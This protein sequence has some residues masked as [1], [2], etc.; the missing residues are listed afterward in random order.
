M[1][2]RRGSAM[3]LVTLLAVLM[4]ITAVT[5]VG[6]TATKNRESYA[7]NKILV[8]RYAA[9]A[10]LQEAQ[11]KIEYED[12]ID[13]PDWFNTA[14]SQPDPVDTRWIPPQG[15]TADAA[16]VKLS[17]F[18]AAEALTRYGLTLGAD[19]YIVEA[20]ATCD[21][22]KA[23]LHMRVSY[24]VETTTSTS[25]SPNP[26][27]LFSKYLVWTT[28]PSDPS[29][30]WWNGISNGPVHIN[31]S[32]TISDKSTRMAMPFTVTETLAY[33]GPPYLT[34]WT[35]AEKD[36]LFDYDNDGALTSTPRPDLLNTSEIDAKTGSG[37]GKPAVTQPSYGDVQSRMLNAA[38]NQTA[39][40]PAL[41][42]LWVDPA[43]PRYQAGGPMYVGTIQYL[44]V[45]F[46]H[47]SSAGV[48]K[49]TA[50]I[51]VTGSSTTR[52]ANVVIP[53]GSP[54]ILYTPARIQSLTG[55]LYGQ[56]T[57]ASTYLGSPTTANWNPWN[58]G[59]FTVMSP[60]S[61]RI[62]DHV[63]LVDQ[64]GRP[65]Y[66]M[67][68]GSTAVAQP[69]RLGLTGV[70]INDSGGA[71][72]DSSASNWQSSGWV[73]KKNPNYNPASP[74]VLGLMCRGDLRVTST[75]QNWI[76]MFAHY[77][78]ENSGRIYAWYGNTRGNHAFLG[79]MISPQTNYF[80]YVVHYSDG[81]VA[82]QAGFT[83]GAYEMYDADFRTSPPPYWIAP[84]GVTTATVTT[85]TVT[86]FP[87][88]IYQINARD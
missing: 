7:L 81:S 14:R 25:S 38:V 47:D 57:V 2:R 84:A 15:T 46:A 3:L 80:G 83:K 88:A 40:S 22:S 21:R 53:P 51:T 71:N 41:A 73:F 87:G 9:E 49:T 42:D 58:L 18:D 8:C 26:A 79:S 52:T 82:H 24:R 68:D 66:W 32:V 23:T 29:V 60:P 54:T 19:E 77:S 50:Q 13:V 72:V 67:Y 1:N 69:S 39:S 43:N 36:R 86:A 45:R 75:P 27:D 30:T 64:D 20:K 5:L 10:A 85:T 56:L 63:V 74:S 44:T 34:S 11:F 35:T 76:G 62:D 4:L 78:A 33:L 28:T 55:N 59:S 70:P 61:I 37:G 65:K 6:F 12:S 17:I 48:K 31:G 16:L